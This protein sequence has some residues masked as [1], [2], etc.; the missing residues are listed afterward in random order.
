MKRVS[1][2]LIA[3]SSLLLVAAAQGASAKAATAVCN[4]GSTY[5]GSSHR[6]ACARHDGVKQ[7]L[8]TDEAQPAPAAK[9]TPEVRRTTEMPAAERPA[10]TRSRT[11]PAATR[12]SADDVWVNTATRTY[13]CKGDRWYGKT[14]QGAYMPEGR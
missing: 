3:A 9:S 4:D 14:R 8:D 2:A 10:D 7:W 1:L 5:S 12:A 6:G 11:R 13:H